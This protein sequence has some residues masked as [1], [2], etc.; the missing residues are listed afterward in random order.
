MSHQRHAQTS[1]GSSARLDQILHRV[2]LRGDFYCQTELSAPWALEMPAIEDS[3]SFHVVTEGHCVLEVDGQDRVQ[4]RSGDLALVPH[5]RGHVLYGEMNPAQRD[6]DAHATDPAQ[7]HVQPQRV[8]LLPQ[9]YL[10]P[11]HSRL[12]HGGGG[13]PS[14]LICGVVGFEEPAARELARRLPPLLVMT[15]DSV[16]AHSRILDSIRLMGEELAARQVGGDVVASRLADIIVIQAIRAWL[17]EDR[18]ERTDWFTAVNDDRIGPA[19]LAIHADPGR[20]W[21]VTSLAR[22]AMMSRS[23]FSARFTELVGETPIAYL[24]R[25]RMDKARL[26]LTEDQ[27]SAA[28][29]AGKVGYGSE[30]AFSRAFTRLVGTTPGAWRRSASRRG[31]TSD[32]MPSTG[33]P[34]PAGQAVHT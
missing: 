9:E 7:Q 29:V 26:L 20:G 6:E 34:A 32:L 33:E 31:A 25:W 5:G 12:V 8:D 15:R 23:L 16:A 28:Q 22:V 11:L 30:A 3:I 27:M 4:L 2:R 17:V 24:T 1:S 13:S 21:D 14:R 10:G 19:L 18:A